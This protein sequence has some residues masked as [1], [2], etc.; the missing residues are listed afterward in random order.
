MTITINLKGRLGNQLFQYATLRSLAI[1]KG[2]NFYINTSLEWHGQN[3]LLSYF[4]IAESSPL[5]KIKYFYYQPVNSNYLDTNVFNIEDDTLLDGH[6]ENIEYFEEHRNIIMNELT[7]KD[8]AINNY[9]DN[10]I[11]NITKNESKLVGIHF[12]RG[13]LVQQVSNVDEY[14][15]QT[16]EFVKK[17][18]ET[19][20]STN[21]NLTLLFFT[22]GMRKEGAHTNWMDNT[23]DSDVKW[24]NEFISCY[25]NDFNVYISPGTIENNE[26][27]DYSLLSKCDYIITPHQ[28]TF[29]FMAYYV[30]T[31]IIELFSPTNLYGVK[32]K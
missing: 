13:D 4:N 31:K 32:S 14:N 25:K 18:L 5:N 19:I 7:I 1:K 22:G 17:S 21:S 8:E 26:L 11:K 16:I 29:S 15:K 28:S 23:H 27:I 6:F 10:Y 20:I 3:S 12:R 2:Y 30:N 24:L 9:T